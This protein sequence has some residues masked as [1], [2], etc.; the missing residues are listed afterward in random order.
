MHCPR[1]MSIIRIITLPLPLMFKK[2][3]SILMMFTALAIL[4]GHNLIP[5][6]HHHHEFEY[7]TVE[8]HHGDE[9]DGNSENEE[10]DFGHLFSN[11]QHGENGITFLSNHFTNSLS[12][13]L[14]P[15]VAV[16]TE[17]FF[18]QNITEFVRQNS[19]PCKSEYRNS[20]Y[21]LP[22]GLRA[23]PTFIV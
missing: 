22:P 15:S 11:F 5:H 23:P 17:V 10:S 6:H 14:S 13:Q 12:K 1:Q 3:S 16:L 2:Y 4:L 21:L 20:Q 8:H 7:Y 18:F 9:D 19:P